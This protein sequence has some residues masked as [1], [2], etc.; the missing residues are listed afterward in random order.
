M[1]QNDKEAVFAKCVDFV[2][3]IKEKWDNGLSKDLVRY[4][5]LFSAFVIC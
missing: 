2:I 5:L 1:G 4:S 3:G